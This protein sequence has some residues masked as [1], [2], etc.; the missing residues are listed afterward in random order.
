MTWVF[1]FTPN[2][3][4]WRKD[5]VTTLFDFENTSLIVGKHDAF[6]EKLYDKVRKQKEQNGHATLV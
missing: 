2:P 1:N 6:L 3:G 4:E 5:I